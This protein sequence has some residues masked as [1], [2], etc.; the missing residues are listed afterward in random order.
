MSKIQKHCQVDKCNR[1][2]STHCFCCNK[3]V[4]T[5]HFTEHIDAVKAQIDPLANDINSMVEQIQTLTIEQ[6]TES[7]FSQLH[8]WRDDMHKSIDDIFLAKS[9]EMEDLIEKNTAQFL[10]HKKEQSETMMKVQDDA[11]QLVEDGDATHEQIQLLRKRL[12]DVETKLTTFGKDFICIS[13]RLL[14][15]SLVTVS[16]NLNKSMPSELF[17]M[18]HI[19]KHMQL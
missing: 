16:S 6:M 1:A 8:Q 15:K 13:T 4:C 11:R 2:A 14:T 5:R 7:S 12:S 19:S 10:E 18:C 9:K 3:S 17:S